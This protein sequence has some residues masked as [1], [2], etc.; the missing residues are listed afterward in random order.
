MGTSATPLL[1][2][3]NTTCPN[4]NDV[5]QDS[6][7]PAAKAKPCKS[8]TNKTHHGG[9]PFI[10]HG[11]GAACEIALLKRKPYSMCYQCRNEYRRKQD[12]IN[13]QRR[14]QN[15]IAHDP[16]KALLNKCQC[17][18]CISQ[19]QREYRER[20]KAIE[21]LKPT[22]RIKK[23][24]STPRTGKSQIRGGSWSTPGRSPTEIAPKP[25]RSLIS[26]HDPPKI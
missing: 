8:L 5:K 10:D 1:P 26:T 20:K 25:R 7:V 9:K 17:R 21:D 6:V 19:R 3:A 24:K 15:P 2:T 13:T 22:N 23:H 12:Q 18:G 4:P 11:D 14:K 16:D